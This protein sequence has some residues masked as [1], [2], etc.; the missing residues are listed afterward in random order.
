LTTAGLPVS[1]QLVGP[2]HADAL[3]LRAASAL[4]SFLPQWG[5]PALLDA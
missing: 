3:V 1:A 5:R 2:M 4:E